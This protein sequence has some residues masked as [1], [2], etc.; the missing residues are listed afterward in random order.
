MAQMTIMGVED[1][2]KCCDNKALSIAHWPLPH[3]GSCSLLAR[4]PAGLVCCEP[5]PNA[6]LDLSL[7]CCFQ[8]IWEC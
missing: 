8:H 6:K 2:G 4:P 7:L 5:L 1:S 3:W